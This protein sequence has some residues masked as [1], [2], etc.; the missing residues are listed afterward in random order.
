MSKKIKF[1]KEA[2]KNYK[3]SG[4]VVPSSRFLAN[5][6]LKP[7]NF[8]NAKVIVELGPGNGAITKY[9]LKKLQPSTMLVCFEINDTFY[10]ELLQINNPQL[11]VLKASAEDVKEELNK[12]GFDQADY[13]ISSLPLT[14][15]PSNLSEN[16]LRASYNILKNKGYFMQFQYSLSYYKK[17]KK[18]FG[19]NISL[20]FEPLNFPP[21]FVYKCT[22]K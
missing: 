15:L 11:K 18:I 5:E 3:T 20:S 1:F 2:L 9:I 19:E 12:L 22:K 14:I 8:K 10:N 6:I 13:I 16:I 4:T 17:L 21:A 7:V